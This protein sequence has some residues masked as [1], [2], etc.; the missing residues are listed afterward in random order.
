ME[1]LTDEELDLYTGYRRPKEQIDW[2]KKHK[3]V[4]FTINRQN[5]PV[6]VFKHVFGFRRNGK[7][8]QEHKTDISWQPDLATL[9]PPTRKHSH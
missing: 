2:L 8:E 1:F 6:V 3:L 7:D 9:P 4:P 5:K